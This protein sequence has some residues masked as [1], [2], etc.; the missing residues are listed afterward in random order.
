MKVTIVA[1]MPGTGKTTLIHQLINNEDI[2]N[3]IHHDEILINDNFKPAVFAAL[4]DVEDTGHMFIESQDDK[5]LFFDDNEKEFYQTTLRL[6]R[7]WRT[8]DG[9]FFNTEI[10]LLPF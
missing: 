9:Y 5:A 2:P 6:F 3:A 8:P 4:E 10:G 1:G 7:T